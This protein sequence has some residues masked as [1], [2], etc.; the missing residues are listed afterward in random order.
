MSDL[1]CPH[2]GSKPTPALRG[3]G[4]QD[5]P[6]YDCGTMKNGPWM[7][8]LCK[9]RQAHKKTKA[10]RDELLNL[11]DQMLDFLSAV[12]ASDSEE[13]CRLSEA[14]NKIKKKF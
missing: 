4:G 3:R 1:N 10:E 5:C 14:I 11:V 9:E 8:E 7:S 6:T 13:W 2:C 12:G